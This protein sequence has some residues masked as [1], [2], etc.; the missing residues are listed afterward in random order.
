MEVLL[1]TYYREVLRPGHE[2]VPKKDRSHGP[3]KLATTKHHS[4]C[5]MAF[6]FEGCGVCVSRQHP[7]FWAPCLQLNDDTCSIIT[8]PW[9]ESCLEYIKFW[10]LDEK[11]AQSWLTS[12]YKGTCPSTNR[13]Y[14]VKLLVEMISNVKLNHFDSSINKQDLLLKVTCLRIVVGLQDSF[15]TNSRINPFLVFPDFVK[16]VDP[17]R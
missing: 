7:I 8:N 1:V 3:K 6:C 17:P 9:L 4:A 12:I 2:V 5:S 13:N 10:G 16:P 15:W 14:T 11:F